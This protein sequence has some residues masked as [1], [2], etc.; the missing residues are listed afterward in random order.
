MP[1]N[2]VPN[3]CG[4]SLCQSCQK[5]EPKEKSPPLDGISFNPIKLEMTDDK[6]LWTCQLLKRKS[7]IVY[8]YFF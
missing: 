3:L 1:H 4:K 7:Q 5:T 6:N 2:E 8:S